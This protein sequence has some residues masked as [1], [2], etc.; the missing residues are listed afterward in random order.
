MQI[1]KSNWIPR[2]DTFKPFSTP[3]MPDDANVTK[4]IDTRNQWK[5]DLIHQHFNKEDAEAILSIFLF[6]SPQVD[7]K[8]CTLLRVDIKLL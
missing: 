8:V 7:E 2:P 6:R 3:S 4:L 5:V 1:Y